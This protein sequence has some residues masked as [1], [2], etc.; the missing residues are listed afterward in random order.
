MAAKTKKSEPKTV[1]KRTDPFKTRK[2]KVPESKANDTVTPPDEVA[3][4]IDAFR[5]CQEQAKHF[6]GE[7]T[8]HKDTILTFA[9]EEYTKRLMSGVQKSFKIMGEETMVTYIVTD[10]SA[11][12]TEEDVADIAERF[13]GD[14]AE[15]LVVR[16]Y[17]SIRFDGDVLAA[18]YDKIVEALQVLPEDVLSKLFKPMLMKAA[19]GAAEAAK[20]HTKNQSELRS[21]LKALRIK[22]YIK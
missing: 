18:N 14:A 2:A 1:G 9:E 7:A 16:D 3:E 10:S 17:A 22:N 12:L 5:E 20:K 6:E 15:D 19:P 13:G 11:G 8:I 21:L 4:A